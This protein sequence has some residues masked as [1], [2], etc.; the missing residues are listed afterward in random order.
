MSVLK[1][2]SLQRWLKLLRIYQWS[3]NTLVVVPLVTAHSFNLISIGKATGAFFAFSL[4]ASGIYLINDWVDVESDREHWAKKDRPLAAG[5]IPVLEAI[6]VALILVT[7]ATVGAF[8]LSF[9]FG[10]VLLGYLAF[11][12]AYVFALKQKAIIDVVTLAVLYV[13]R[14]VGGAAAIAVVPSDWLLTF[15]MFIFLALALVKRYTELAGRLDAN[16]PEP[17]DRNYRKGDLDTIVALAAAS[18]FNAVTVFALY[19][20]S[21]AVRELYTYPQLLWLICPI[22]IYWIARVLL[23]AS[24]HLI[25]EDPVLFALN[26]RVSWAL[27]AI[28]GAILMAAM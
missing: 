8:L 3:K 13:F 20:S 23:F 16:L 12:T 2:D 14:V 7:V 5:T 21:D 4:A 1:A 19:L 22:L 11:A 15:S 24:R 6:V 27:A 25:D 17:K 18:G 10:L 28:V 26:D 9:W